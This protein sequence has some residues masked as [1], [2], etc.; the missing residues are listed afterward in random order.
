MNENDADSPTTLGPTPPEPIRPEPAPSEPITSDAET[1]VVR[2][3]T[4]PSQP[5][6]A[7]EGYQANRTLP[8]GV[9]LARQL[10]RRRTRLALGFLAVLP[11]LLLLAFEVGDDSGGRGSRGFVD[12]ATTSGV[13]FAVFTLFV[14]TSFLLV[15]VV[16]LFFG[17]TVAS[18]ASW[19]S[20]KYLLASPVPRSRLLRQ[21]AIVS[22]LLSVTGLLL[23]TAVA[24]IAGLIWYGNG[25]LLSPSGEALAFPVGLTRLLAATA[26]LAVHLTWIAGLALCL[27]VATDAPLGAVGGAVLVSILSQILDQITAL[28]DLRTFLP[29][30]Y[31][32]AWSDLLTGEVEW[33]DLANGACSGLAYGT[34]FLAV[35][36]W[37]FRRKDITS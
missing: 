34:V 36:V 37:Y 20:L 16:A 22:A 5:D 25:E 2:M 17:D 32:R 8:I 26:F 29:T 28:G 23:L 31:S 12:T 6:G 11:L 19:S 18:E 33:T 4:R 7:V 14:S 13:N 9:E 1:A 3:T 15:V 30:H 10:R 27:S 35:A 21:K 24:L